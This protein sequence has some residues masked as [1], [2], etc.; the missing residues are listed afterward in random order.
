MSSNG[1]TKGRCV[2]CSAKSINGELCEEHAESWAR[3]QGL[4][5]QLALPPLQGKGGAPTPI[6][7]EVYVE[8][9]DRYD[10]IKTM[11]VDAERIVITTQGGDVVTRD[12]KD[13]VPPWRRR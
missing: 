10:T 4:I 11:S 5:A 8:Q 7:V 2:M 13:G 6:A 1:H 9:S 3:T 12:M